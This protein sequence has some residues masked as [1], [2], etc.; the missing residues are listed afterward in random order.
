MFSVKRFAA[1]VHRA[2]TWRARLPQH[3][4][5]FASTRRLQLEA[6]EGR[7]CPSGGYLVV[8]SYDNNS[9]LRYN[10]STGAFVD[11]IDPKNLANLNTPGSVLFG[12][13]QN[14]YVPDRYSKTS[15]QNVLQYN[16]T[17]GVFQSV[18]AS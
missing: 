8:A 2:W 12:P 13:D 9:I 5:R 18:F 4:K 14:L 11:Q 1:M 7:L 6:L 3:S 10:E 16:G 15:Q 17:T